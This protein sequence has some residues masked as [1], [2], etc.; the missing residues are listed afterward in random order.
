VDPD[1]IQEVDWE[2]QSDPES[3]V[4]VEGSIAVAIDM[5]PSGDRV[6]VAVAGL[7]EDGSVHF[8]VI[9]Y[10]KGSAWVPKYLASLSRAVDPEEVLEP[11][12]FPSLGYDL[13]CPV[14]W[15]PSATVGALR[16]KLEEEGVAMEDVT[17]LEYSESCGAFKTHISAGTAWHRGTEILNAAFL[18][19][20]R[21]VRPEGGW[22]FGRMKSTGDISPLVGSTL[23]VRGVD[24]YGERNPG[25]WEL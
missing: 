21:K 20:V 7:R 3:Q 12:E 18:A 25:V 17:E 9:K 15:T 24:K 13:M 22:I 5:P 23:A 8:G 1:A 19:S 4:E 16:A 10:E 11:G 2:R 6:S 14:L